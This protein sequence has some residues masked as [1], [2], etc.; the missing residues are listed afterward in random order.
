MQA[1]LKIYLA[2]P[3]VFFREPLARG[4]HLQARC[5]AFGFDGHF[6]LDAALPPADEPFGAEA[7]GNADVTTDPAPSPSGADTALPPTPASA[8][9]IYRANIALLRGCDAVMANLQDF[10][11]TEPDS[12]TVFEVGYAV[13]LGLPVWAY[14]APAVPI[15][16]QVPHDAA[17]R[18]GDDWAVEDFALPR[19]LMLACAIRIV[20][21]DVDAC[22]ADMRSIL[23]ARTAPFVPG[24]IRASK[25]PPDSARGATSGGAR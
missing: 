1:P 11:G 4:Q 10:R 6:P 12:G 7:H 25:G 21:G 20:E 16:D 24:W 17:G 19:N 2:G 23:S 14:G 9:R 5:A 22:L 18:D 15:I 3:D 8:L 13:A